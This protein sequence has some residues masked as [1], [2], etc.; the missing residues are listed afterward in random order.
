MRLSQ[1]RYTKRRAEIVEKRKSEDLLRGGRDSVVLE[2]RVVK[3]QGIHKR[4]F[5]DTWRLSSL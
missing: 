2:I 1:R 5:Q 3:N 4:E